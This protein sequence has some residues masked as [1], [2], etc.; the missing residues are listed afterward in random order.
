M[1]NVQT[2]NRR[3][4]LESLAAILGSLGLPQIIAAD[5]FNSRWFVQK[6]T[7]NTFF[8]VNDP[9]LWAL[10][11]RQSALLSRAREGL[12]KLDPADS[13]RIVRLVARRCGL[14]FVK[15]QSEQVN[16][17]H[18]TSQLAD[19]RPFFKQF[20]LANRGIRVVLIDRKRERSQ[21]LTGADFLY[22]DELSADFPFHRFLSKW[23]RRRTIEADDWQAA[24]GTR[25]GFGWEGV[26]GDQ[27]PWAA[28]KCA[29][30]RAENTLCPNCDLPTILVNFGNPWISMFERVP[31]FV[32]VCGD[33]DRSFVDEWIGD[34]TA[35][36]QANLDPQVMPKY[37]MVWN[38]RML[39]D[40]VSN[41]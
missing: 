6:I 19:L 4:V 41:A 33:C 12:S 15:L 29:W 3:E 25:S 9:A 5:Q 39:W 27:I 40:A 16:V 36:L 1:Q 21:V 17:H 28:L 38:R 10:E 24:P 26:E 22:G 7:D 37:Q 8:E 30:R 2:L 20:R 23:N 18:W 34:A 35:W 11:N 32:R 31:K 14:N 13:D